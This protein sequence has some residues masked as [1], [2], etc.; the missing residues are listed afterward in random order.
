MGHWSWPV[1]L[2]VHLGGKRNAWESR[3][4]HRLSGADGEEGGAI[5]QVCRTGS[6]GWGWGGA[7]L[8][9]EWQ[10]T[11]MGTQQQ[12]QRPGEGTDPGVSCSG[13]E[14]TGLTRSEATR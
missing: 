14:E 2:A 12:R 5:S 8:V 1:E 13:A 7:G 6:V 10:R 9:A 4:E 11:L 3:A